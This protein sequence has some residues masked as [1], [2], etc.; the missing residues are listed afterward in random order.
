MKLNRK[1]IILIIFALL[2]L[3][4]VYKLAISKTLHYYKSYSDINV[5][6]LDIKNS[7]NQENILLSKNKNLDKILTKL[8]YNNNG[9]NQQNNLLKLINQKASQ[10]N[11]KIVAF[12]EPQIF[13][14]DK[15]KIIRYHFSVEG[16]F[17]KTLLLLNHLENNPFIG[18][19]KHF[20]TLKK[21][22]FKT[23]SNI[24]TTYIVVEKK[25]F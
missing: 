24:I 10:N 11:L 4:I 16:N 5:K 7:G 3:V 19:I 17:N 21:K 9:D 12:E 22:N 20:S 18:T 6:L 13:I 1:N 14:E 8:N 25:E 23:N 2:S 15:T